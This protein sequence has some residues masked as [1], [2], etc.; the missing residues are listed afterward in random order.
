[1]Q[2]RQKNHRKEDEDKTKRNRKINNKR[3][4]NVAE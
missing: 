2:Q 3:E 1:M 4:K